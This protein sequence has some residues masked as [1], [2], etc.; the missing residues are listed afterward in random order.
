MSRDGVI[1]VANSE[2]LDYDA[3][4]QSVSMDVVAIDTAGNVSEP[5]QVTVAINNLADEASEQPP[6]PTPT[7]VEPPRSSG[8]SMGWLTLLLAPIAFLRRR[9]K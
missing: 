7:P 9:T 8:G 2:L 1:T 4:L 6:A 3:G 5:A